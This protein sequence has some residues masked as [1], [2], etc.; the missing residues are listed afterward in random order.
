[1]CIWWF[2]PALK[3]IHFCHGCLSFIAICS[4]S[5]CEAFCWIF[6]YSCMQLDCKINIQGVTAAQIITL[7][8]RGFLNLLL[9]KIVLIDLQYLKQEESPRQLQ[10]GSLTVFHRL[11]N[12]YTWFSL[13]IRDEGRDDK[14]ST[15]LLEGRT[16]GASLSFSV[17]PCS[18][19]VFTLIWRRLSQTCAVLK[20]LQRCHLVWSSQIAFI[21]FT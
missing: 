2:H 17:L 10:I 15:T 14:C 9:E 21:S 8:G 6:I 4:I 7:A 18:A 11:L 20:V 5:V 13:C 12:W 1:M 16:R 19:V 3:V